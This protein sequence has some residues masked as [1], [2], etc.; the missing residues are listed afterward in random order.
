MLAALAASSSLPPQ[1]PSS[2]NSAPTGSAPASTVAP[3]VPVASAEGTQTTNSS[4][5]PEA[6]IGRRRSQRLSAKKTNAVTGDVAPVE[7]SEPTSAPALEAGTSTAIEA[8]KASVES[9]PSEALLSKMSGF[10]GSEMGASE[11]LV[12]EE[13]D[14]LH[15]DFTDEEV[16]AEVCTLVQLSVHRAD[17]LAGL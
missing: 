8:T 2:S 17:Y 4:S 9:A 16:D 13:D 15:A 10:F 11:T 7:T 12:N 6:K 3:Q 1:I 5:A 14:D